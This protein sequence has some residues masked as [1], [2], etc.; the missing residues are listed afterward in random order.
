[1]TDRNAGPE[2]GEE[3]SAV[4]VYECNECG[5]RVHAEHQPGPCPVCEGE[6]MD[7]SQSR[8]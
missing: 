1:M 8:E 6:M 3:H 4:K 7:I 2:T 5:H